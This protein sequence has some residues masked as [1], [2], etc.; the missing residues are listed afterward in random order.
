[1]ELEFVVRCSVSAVTTGGEVNTPGADWYSTEGGDLCGITEH[2][3][4]KEQQGS[5]RPK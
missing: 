5:R 4:G 3:G 2:L 1:M